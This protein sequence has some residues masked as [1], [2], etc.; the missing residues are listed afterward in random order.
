MGVPLQTRCKY[1]QTHIHSQ[2]IWPKMIFEIDVSL[3]IQQKCNQIVLPIVRSP[4]QSAGFVL[5]SIG[6]SVIVW[7]DD[8]HSLLAHAPLEVEGGQICSPS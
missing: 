5:G 1:V 2:K 3:A 4:V 6:A 8:L 7:Y